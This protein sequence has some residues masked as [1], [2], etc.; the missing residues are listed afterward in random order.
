MPIDMKQFSAD[1]NKYVSNKNSKTAVQNN[2]VST[3]KKKDDI[4]DYSEEKK[5]E[6][7]AKK[8]EQ[9]KKNKNFVQ[10]LANVPYAQQQNSLLTSD[11][12]YGAMR[13]A[14]KKEP[15]TPKTEKARKVAEQHK[16][17]TP[18]EQY[19]SKMEQSVKETEARKSHDAK[20][21]EKMES[22][23]AQFNADEKSAFN[24]YMVMQA[25]IKSGQAP[26]VEQAYDEGVNALIKKYGNDLTVMADA[27]NRKQNKESAKNL[28]ELGRKATQYKVDDVTAKAIA[29]MGIGNIPSD[30]RLLSEGAA[31]GANLIGGAAQGIENIGQ[32]LADIGKKAYGVDGFQTIDAN[33][34]S[35]F[36]AFAQGERQQNLDDIANSESLNETGKKI[37]STLYQAGTSAAD[38]ILRAAAG[39]GLS[40]MS[41][42]LA[43]LGSFGSAVSEA[44]AKGATPAQALANGVVQGGLEILTEKIPTENLLKAFKNPSKKTLDAVVTILKNAASE[45]TE[46]EVSLIVGTFAEAAILKGA[47]SYGNTVAKYTESGMNAADAIAQA[48]KDLWNEAVNTAMTTAISSVA[49][50]AASMAAGSFRES[51]ND[52]NAPATQE[53]ADFINDYYGRRYDA[54]LQL[55]QNNQQTEQAAQQA[56]QERNNSV[57]RAVD[58]QKENGKISN[59]EAETIAADPAA[60]QI[61]GI[62]PNGK[63]KSELRAEIKE[64][65]A[66]AASDTFQDNSATKND[67]AQE[68]QPAEIDPVQAAVDIALKN[69][70]GQNE[71]QEARPAA[72]P[73]FEAGKNI[74]ENQQQAQQEQTS[75]QEQQ[76]TQ[77]TEQQNQEEANQQ[78]GEQAENLQMQRKQKTSKVYSNTYENA[79]DEN[80]K[81]IGSES[82]EQ[83]PDVAKY[84]PVSESQS[85]ESAE[86]R[87]NTPEKMIAEADNLISK[88]GWSGSDNDTAMKTLDYLRKNGDSKRFMELASKQRE[89]ATQA[90]QLAQSFAKYSRV[91]PESAAIEAATTIQDMGETDIDKK[92]FKNQGFENWKTDVVDTVLDLSNQIDGVKDGDTATMKDIIRQIA[93]FRNTTA[94]FG[95]SNKLTPAAENILKS[96]DDFDF[97]KDIVSRQIATIP[98][99]FERRTKGEITKA[100]RMKSMLFSIPTTV[101]NLAG[102]GEVYLLDTLSDSTSGKLADMIMS[103]VTGKRT[104]GSEGLW[105]KTYRDA[106][107]DAAKKASLCVELDVP[108]ESD[109]KY[110]SGDTRTF[111]PKSN[112]VGRWYSAMEKYMKYGLEVTDTLAQSGTS[113]SIKNSLSKLGQKSGLSDS[114]MQ[115]ISEYVGNR[116]VYKEGRK[117][118]QAA[119]GMKKA[120]NEVGIGDYVMPFAAVPTEEAQVKADYAGV[121]LIEGVKE[122]VDICRD[123]KAG[124]EIDVTRQ[125]KACSDFGRG[126][127]GVATIALFTALCAKG[128]IEVHEDKDRD[129][130]GLEKA[131]GK[132]DA[133]INLS[134]FFRMLTGEKEDSLDD[135]LRISMPQFGIGYSQAYIGYMISEEGIAS[136]P[137]ASFTGIMDATLEMPMMQ[138]ISDLADIVDAAKQVSE[139]GDMEAVP[140]AVGN[141]VGNMASSFIPAPVGQLANVVD[142]YYRDTTGKDWVESAKNK[143]VS[144]IPY[145]SETLP[146]K[147]SGT[148]NEQRRYA[149]GNELLGAYDQFITPSMY[150]RG[151]QDATAEFIDSVFQNVKDVDGAKAIYPDYLAPG[152][153]KV[154]GE[155]FVLSGKEN[156]EKY[157]KT[158]GE[159]IS[160][161]YGAIQNNK[162][163]D[164]LSPEEQV[165]VLKTAKQYAAQIA[166]S[167]VSAYVSK[168][169]VG[170][171][172]EIAQKL[173]TDKRISSI[174][175]VFDDVTKDLASG[176]KL[177]RQYGKDLDAFWNAAQKNG[178]VSELIEGA[179]GTAEKYLMAREDGLSTD[180]FIHGLKA[181]KDATANKDLSKKEQANALA[182]NIDELVEDGTISE[183]DADFF[184]EN[185]AIFNFTTQTTNQYDELKNTYGFNARDAQNFANRIAKTNERLK[186]EIGGDPSN[187][188]MYEAI[189]KDNPDQPD[190]VLIAMM[191]A[192]T[193]DYKP[194][195]KSPQTTALK[196]D[197]MHDS[198]SMSAEQIYI[199]ES[200]WYNEEL[201]SKQKKSQLNAINSSLYNLF[202]GKLNAKLKSDYA[203]TH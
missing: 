104:I 9:K 181:Y 4:W 118:A 38:N 103:N 186:E 82:M 24:R 85:L 33:A 111:S 41:L 117:A 64:A 48:D 53:S 144:K 169:P 193:P 183:K 43:G 26:S 168:V 165:A 151:T 146:K 135:D 13:Q 60:L 10:N 92:F 12:V 199:A 182:A 119:V 42:G 7:P 20:L 98:R 166:K 132:F 142:P 52:T 164:T 107:L 130:E 200:I 57:N 197:Y 189:V 152:K 129:K 2:T 55:E 195:A 45:I 61:L 47:S 106:A 176:K 134:N 3:P 21:Q 109:T 83:N 192:I 171:P 203:A 194:D 73:I 18:S 180:S 11:S 187:A 17:K 94:W 87:T 50:N 138:N 23:V 157:Q 154:N 122:M 65:V 150:T 120:L 35:K 188:Q 36:T 124:K 90:G 39:G 86:A 19:A 89:Q 114:E 167:S 202:K 100:I 63:T 198:L 153:F 37:A 99:D 161:Y 34:G 67:T 179:D 128:I 46:E 40:E 30:S 16:E 84:T 108:M 163:F 145:L 59:R 25:Q 131:T 184:R 175:S 148:G 113:E 112:F 172:E 178:N 156:T 22:Q 174:D 126:M 54:Q 196:I 62:D 91:T 97:L 158:Y 29:D 31:I 78:Q 201:S 170:T 32:G 70:N 71:Q 102:N 6:V 5:Q 116:R 95:Y 141:F 143:V 105:D 160:Q 15:I 137:K 125:R 69:Q 81:A 51:Q 56:E 101:S 123:A 80:I 177:S 133:Q 191:Q 110:S 49:S 140:N 28:E 190:D 74:G 115:S 27:M 77:Q 139:D 58:A 44:S 66:N 96:I 185:Y 136:Y 1:L 173:I 75:T 155:D 68:A 72:N 88:N 149:E 162:Y 8:E 127:T 159:S 121:G 14:P 147:Y 93:Q 76:T 79:T